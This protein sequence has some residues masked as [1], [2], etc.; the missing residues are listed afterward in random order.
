M[1]S[2]RPINR[3]SS[4]RRPAAGTAPATKTTTRR[5]AGRPNTTDKQRAAARATEH[6]ETR[7]RRRLPRL[8]PGGGSA[9]WRPASLLTVAALL[10][11]AFAVTAAFRP[12]VDDSNRAFLDNSETE[13]VKAAAAQVLS[14][15]YGTDAKNL[16]GYKDAAKRVL[17]GKA[18]ADSDKYLD[19]VVQAVQ[20]TGTKADIR[21]DPIGVTLLTHDHAEVVANMT[22]GL[23]KDGA[24]QQ[25]ATGPILVRLEKVGD[26]WLASDLP[27][28]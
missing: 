23:T 1:E 12:G 8:R 16:A 10:L 19:T 9:Q 3:V 13:R 14:T 15:V 2:R 5:V 17:T 27:D 28:R 26:R 6:A 22:V 11:A 21:T 24:V 18:L 25:S 4:R 20:Q 7:T